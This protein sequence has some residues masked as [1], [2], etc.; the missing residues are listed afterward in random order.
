MRTRTRRTR[1][2]MSA[3]STAASF[4]RRIS[5]TRSRASPSVPDPD[6]PSRLERLLGELKQFFGL[7]PAPP[8]GA[9]QLFVW[10]VLSPQSSPQQRNSAFAALKRNLALTPDSMWKV[11]PKKLEDS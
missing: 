2:S 5:T 3:T 4:R 6:T 8:G 11:A 9:F 7:L 10:E 1:S